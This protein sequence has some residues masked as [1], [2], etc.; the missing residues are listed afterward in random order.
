MDQRRFTTLQHAA[1][2]SV[3]WRPDFASS[4]MV[5]IGALSQS[6]GVDR[7]RDTGLFWVFGFGPIEREYLAH[8]YQRVSHDELLQRLATCPYPFPYGKS[9]AAPRVCL[10]PLQGVAPHRR[11]MAVRPMPAR[12]RNVPEPGR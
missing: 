5:C 7:D 6:H 12:P 8:S 9:V 3:R 10:P 4:P 2:V 11:A 1:R